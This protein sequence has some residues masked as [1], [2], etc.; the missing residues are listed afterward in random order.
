[1]LLPAL[2]V[3]WSSSTPAL[4]AGVDSCWNYFEVELTHCC[5]QKQSGKSIKAIKTD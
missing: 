4:V 1:M 2:A 3:T 5:W